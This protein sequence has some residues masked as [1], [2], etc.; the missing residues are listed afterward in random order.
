MAIPALDEPWTEADSEIVWALLSPEAKRERIL[1]TAWHL[2]STE[3]LD[4]P[5]PAVAAAAGTG[6]GSLYR[7]FPSKRD[8]VA[9]LVTRRLGQTQHAAE[10]AIRQ[11]GSRWQALKDMLWT[12]VEHQHGDEILGEAWSAV[13]DHEDVARATE[14]TQAAIDVL[15]AAARSEGRVRADVQTFDMRLVFTATRAVERVA[16]DAWKRMLELLIDGLA[17]RTHPR[18]D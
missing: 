10:A 5:M 17:S 15:L 12:I 13:A 14:Q 18:T 8:L 4:A 7:Q 11:P 6:V 2:F 9:A 1:C 3:G 16:P